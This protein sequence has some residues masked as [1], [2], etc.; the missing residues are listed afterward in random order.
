VT[1]DVMAARASMVLFV[2]KEM[3]EYGTNNLIDKKDKGRLKSCLEQ[4]N[5]QKC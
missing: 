4:I 3:V 2:H 5:V 1:K